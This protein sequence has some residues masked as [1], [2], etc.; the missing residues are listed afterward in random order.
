MGLV[1]SALL[2]LARYI[3]AHGLRRLPAVAEALADTSLEL[4]NA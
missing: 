3:M 1:W 2:D 4:E